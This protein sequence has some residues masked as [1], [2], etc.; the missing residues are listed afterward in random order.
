MDPPHPPHPPQPNSRNNRLTERDAE[1]SGISQTPGNPQRI[2]P[3][4]PAADRQPQYSSGFTM[5]PPNLTRRSEMEMVAQKGEETFQRMKEAQ[6]VPYVYVAPETLGG[7][8]TLDE[9]RQRQQTDLRCSKMKTRM[10]QA[11]MER[12]RRQEEEEELQKMKDE[13]RRKAERQEEKERQE[14]QR[15]RE[16]LQQDYLRKKDSF[17]QRFE[18]GPPDPLASSGA[19][20]TS[21][22]SEAAESQWQKSVR[23]VHLEHKRV[24]SAF[25]D[26]L[27]GRGVGSEGGREGVPE[28]EWY[29]SAS[30]D[31]KHE[32]STSTGQQPPPAHLKPE[33]EQSWT[34]E[35][36]R[37]PDYDWD[38][39]KLASLFPGHSKDVLKDILDQCNGDF[40]QACTLL[41]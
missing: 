7:N 1:T 39:M 10:K 26:D 19:T 36:D 27:Q 2:A 4:P 37:D 33:P 31:F 6:R 22:R 13:Q 15:R 16:L 17:L 34:Q 3:D 21:S 9:V 35:A 12:R 41:V 38:L 5:I 24:N 30:N 23:D 8:A 18:R 14:E 40:E 32:P 11:D 29:S 28:A 25:L 20:H